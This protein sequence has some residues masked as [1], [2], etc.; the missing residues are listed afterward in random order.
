MHLNLY[1]EGHNYTKYA[2]DVWQDAVVSSCTPAM[3][4]DEP[5]GKKERE[6]LV[7]THTNL[8]LDPTKYTS[9][10]YASK[11]SEEVKR[12]EVLNAEPDADISGRQQ[13]TQDGQ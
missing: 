13:G 3:E 4:F 7:G 12:M 10:Q 9:S 11:L 1:G 5:Y 8:K 2:F 6:R